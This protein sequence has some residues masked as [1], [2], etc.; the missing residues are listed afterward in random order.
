MIFSKWGSM[1]NLF[2]CHDLL[3]KVTSENLTKII[4]IFSVDFFKRK[5]SY[6]EEERRK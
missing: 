6:E 4:R 5:F 3:D 1:Y 2:S